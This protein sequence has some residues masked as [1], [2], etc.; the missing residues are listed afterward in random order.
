MSS[1]TWL[2]ITILSGFFAALVAIFGKLGISGVDSTL[3]TT[4][5]AGCMFLLLLGVAA[6]TGKLGDIGAIDRR[7][8]L[9]IVLAGVAGALSWICYFWALK[10]GDA[11]RVGPVEKSGLAFVLIFSVLVLG[12]AVTWKTVFGTALV[13]AG[14]AL[15]AL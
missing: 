10:H 15:V 9:Y 12:E 14:A 4:V 3:A 2:P 1:L 8:W 6:A 7:A 5:R 13:I 11:S